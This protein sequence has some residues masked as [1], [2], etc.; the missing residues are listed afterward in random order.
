MPMRAD[1]PDEFSFDGKTVIVTGGNGG[2]GQ[3][4]VNAFSERD[5]NVVIADSAPAIKPL[6]SSGKGKLLDIRTDITKRDSVDAMVQQ[7]LDN[8]GHI[9]VLVNN[10]GG[11]RGRA[12]IL[13]ITPDEIDWLVKLNIYGTLNCTQ[14]VVKVMVEQKA[15][16]IVNISSGA[17]LSGTAGRFDPVYAGC[18]GFINSLTKVLAV[19]LGEFN[20]RVNTIAPGWIV[21][22]RDEQVSEGSF[23]LRLRDQF[24]TPESFNAEYERTGTLH[25]SSG[26]PLKRLGRP[27]DIANAAVYL[28][29]DAARHA[30]GQLLSICGGA[31]MPS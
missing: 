23:W 8:F 7:T 21:P 1:I 3:G 29:S 11:G 14:A 24:G 31:Y 4:I 16:S 15:G 18:K 13:D 25:A 17:G 20:V 19:D 22:E 26:V 9:D 12:R 10:A 2:I 5:A 28:A 6:E 27:R 30:T